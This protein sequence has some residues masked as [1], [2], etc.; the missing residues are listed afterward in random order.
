MRT[1]PYDD[2][3]MQLRDQWLRAVHAID[4]IIQNNIRWT[5]DTTCGCGTP[6]AKFWVQVLTDNHSDIVSTVTATVGYTGEEDDASQF[7]RLEFDLPKI[8]KQAEM[9]HFHILFTLHPDN[10]QARL[11]DIVSGLTQY[12]EL[13]YHDMRAEDTRMGWLW[14][15]I[16]PYAAMFNGDT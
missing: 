13:V 10:I 7:V 1:T 9:E 16:P 12:C 3:L 8:G 11:A 4:P 15:H 5:P 2:F 14:D 6:D